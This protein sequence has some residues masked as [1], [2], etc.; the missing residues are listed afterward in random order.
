MAYGHRAVRSSPRGSSGF[1]RSFGDV[2]E[3]VA[4]GKGDGAMRRAIGQ[5]H[6]RLRPEHVGV[7]QDSRAECT[8]TRGT[9]QL[10][11]ALGKV[12]ADGC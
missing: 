10:V 11:I 5:Q 12:A 2:E 4:P 7:R 3:T 1:H 9:P 8:E 6:C